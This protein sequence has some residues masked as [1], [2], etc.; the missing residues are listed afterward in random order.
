MPRFF[1]T[2][3]TLLFIAVILSGPFLA[4]A[5]KPEIST[6]GIKPGDWARYVGSHP[7]EEYEWMLVSIWNVEGT[8]LNVS[9]SYDV[10]YPYK[11]K[12][13]G[14]YPSQYQ[15]SLTIDVASGKNNLFLF[16]I[17]AN[18]NAG[19]IIPMPSDYP[20]LS[21]NGT[22]LREYAGSERMVVYASSSTMPWLYAASPNLPCTLYWDRETGLLVEIFAEL[23]GISFSSLRLIETNIWSINFLDW[24]AT[25]FVFVALVAASITL[26]TSLLLIFVIKRKI[27]KG[28]AIEVQPK[29]EP[30]EETYSTFRQTLALLYYFLYQHM[31]IALMGIGFLLFVIG[32]MNLTI[33]KQVFSSFSFVFALVSFVVGVLVHSG[34]WA[35][36]RHKIDVGAILLSVSVILL[37]ITTVCAMYREIGALV[38]YREIVGFGAMSRTVKGFFTIEIV[39][40]CPY[41]WLVSPLAHVAISL[42]VCGI[43][44]KILH[45]S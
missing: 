40:L 45:K 29:R 30:D 37:G 20:K 38:P 9:L 14:Y 41:A 17:P 3:L 27:A 18:L 2:T 31:G 22:D 28:S 24:I 32:V 7:Q 15:R 39:F 44:F 23:G 43:F 16:F 1:K 12:V 5:Y 42:A 11:M 36:N 19:D 35:G 10:R 21:V 26:P 34:A 13:H 6:V 25:N 33:H 8:R 4:Y